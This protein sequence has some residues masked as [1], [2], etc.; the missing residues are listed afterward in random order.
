MILIVLFD[1]L[2][3]S[4]CHREKQSFKGSSQL[5]L[6]APLAPPATSASLR[7]A[8]R[9]AGVWLI[10]TYLCKRS[11]QKFTTVHAA[12]FPAKSAKNA[13]ISLAHFAVQ[14]YGSEFNKCLLQDQ[15]CGNLLYIYLAS[16]RANSNRRRSSGFL[17]ETTSVSGVAVVS[18]LTKPTK[19]PCSPRVRRS[20]ASAPKR[21]ASRRS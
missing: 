19:T 18:P 3:K 17:L 4:F 12:L 15:S 16:I 21:V 2:Q 5:T 20:T 13:K 11:I 9:R 1:L 6:C 8:M 10:Y 14:M 7:D